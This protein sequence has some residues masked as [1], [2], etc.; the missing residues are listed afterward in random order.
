LITRPISLF[1]LTAL[2]RIVVGMSEERSQQ[3]NRAKAG[4]LFAKPGV[5]IRQREAQEKE[6]SDYPPLAG[7]IP[8]DRSEAHFGPTISTGSG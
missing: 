6:M 2:H 4:A 1:R 3:R 7:G 5:L 8:V